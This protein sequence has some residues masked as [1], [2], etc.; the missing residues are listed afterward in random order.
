MFRCMIMTVVGFLSGSLM[1]SYFIPLW[2]YNIDIRKNSHDKNPG[3]TN[4]IKAVG[5]RIG[6][7]CMLLDISK[8]FLPVLISI[9]ILNISGFYLIPIIVAPSFGHA[10]SPFVNFNGGK[11]VSTAYGSL[12]GILFI[13]KT[14]FIIAVVMVLFRFIIV[15]KP[16]SLV[17]ILSLIIAYI[18]IL[19]F[20]PLLEV[21]IAVA[22][23]SF[24][25]CFKTYINP[26]KGE[27]SASIWHYCLTYEDSKLK[28]KRV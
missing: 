20:E 27:M 10:F 5:A 24:I 8:A 19:F 3:S 6:L 18:L 17:V 22:I 28:F 25:V 7:L 14:V 21:K 13:S 2:L 1:F 15:V 9:S 12:L 16:D 26:D 4:A 11:A 23:V